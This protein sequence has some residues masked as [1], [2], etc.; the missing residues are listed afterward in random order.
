[1]LS[2]LLACSFRSMF[3]Q[4]ASELKVCR[5]R[6]YSEDRGPNTQSLGPLLSLLSSTHTV[7]FHSCSKL[8]LLW[9]ND[10]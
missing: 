10:T 2:A 8:V 7:Y 6:E 5:Y 4:Q 3:L 1:M 9:V